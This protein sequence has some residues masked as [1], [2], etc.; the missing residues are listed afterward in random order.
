MV[1]LVMTQKGSF[2]LF[3][4]SSKVLASSRAHQFFHQVQISL[5]DNLI[6]QDVCMDP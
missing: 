4:H 5:W 1:M 3:I 6:S 2:G